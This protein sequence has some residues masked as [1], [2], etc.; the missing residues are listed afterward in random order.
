MTVRGI[1]H[2]EGGKKGSGGKKGEVLLVSKDGCKA[3][4]SLATNCL[5]RVPAKGISRSIDGLPTHVCASNTNCVRGVV[6]FFKT[7]TRP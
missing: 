3:V 4:L 5:S 1:E 7:R 2:G 6:H